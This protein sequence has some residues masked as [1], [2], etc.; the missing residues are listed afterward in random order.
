MTAVSVAEFGHSC[1]TPPTSTVAVGIGASEEFDFTLMVSV[2]CP[3]M[4]VPV[5]TVHLYV[6]LDSVGFTLTVKISGWPGAGIPPGPLTEITGHWGFTWAVTV[7]A[8]KR[9]ESS[10]RMNFISSKIHQ[11][12]IK[13]PALGKGRDSARRHDSFR[14]KNDDAWEV[15]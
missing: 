12:S 9:N 3:E 8:A 6:S 10:S 1:G 13:N 2:P 14:R 11:R 7:I 5:L 15:L 4:I